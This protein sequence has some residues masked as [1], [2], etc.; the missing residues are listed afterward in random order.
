[1][2]STVSTSKIAGEVVRPVRA[3]RNG[4]ATDAEL[5]AASLGEGAHGRFG[6]LR[7]PWLDRLE[8]AR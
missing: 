3:A 5:D 4:C 2:P 7:V 1:M 8:L 6:A